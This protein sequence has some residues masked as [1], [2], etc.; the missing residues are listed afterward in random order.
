M[1]YTITTVNVNGIRAAVRRGG[2]EWLTAAEPDVITMQEVRGSDAHL[3]A[4]LAGT[5]FE[6]WHR[7]H[8]VSDAAGRA[9]VAVL[10]RVEPDAL[11][12]GL[13]DFTTDGRW[14]EVDL[15]SP[16]HGVLTV[17]SAYV[18]TGEADT[19]KQVE[20]MRFMD[21]MKQRFA[22]FAARSA[23]DEGEALITG[24]LNVAH[25]DV[26]IKNWKGNVKKSGF[27]PQ[28]RAYFDEWLGHGW[29]R[30]AADPSPISHDGDWVDLGRKFGGDGPGPYTWWSWRGK[31]FDNDSGWRIDYQLATR[32]L[33]ERADSALVGRAP[34]YAERW[35]DHAPLTVTFS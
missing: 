10:S 25:R 4:A 8:A 19:D 17:V 2:I 33:A 23:A 27:L 5:A 24:D 3:D 1:A 13:D 22:E 12:V 15:P 32:R 16:Q 6:G 34:T 21:A 26:D 31:A 29:D 11:R 14:I 28:E 30:D 20:K 9:G 7:A 35:S 18:H